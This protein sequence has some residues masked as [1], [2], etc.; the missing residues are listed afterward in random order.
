MQHMKQNH[1]IEELEDF[2]PY[3]ETAAPGNP[4]PY[5]SVE[6]EAG[7]TRRQ[8]RWSWICSLIAAG[9]M[10]ETLFFK[11]TAAPESVYIFSKMGTD[12]WMRWLGG[13]LATGAMLAAIVSHLTWLGT[14]VQND[15]GL[16]F[17]MALVTLTCGATVLFLHRRRIPFM[18]ALSSW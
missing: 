12:P 14:S 15:H 18:T 13:M 1:H 10:V 2:E 16:L 11:F 9:V 6:P 4:R 3:R 5:K 7:L 8:I 17:C